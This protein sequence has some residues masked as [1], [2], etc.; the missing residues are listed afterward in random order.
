MNAAIRQFL[1]APFVIGSKDMVDHEGKRVPATASTIYLSPTAAGAAESDDIPA[2]S[3]AVAI[4]AR[5]T[6]DLESFRSA[7]TKVAAAKALKLRPLRADPTDP[8][9]IMGIVFA[10]RATAPMEDFAAALEALNATTPSERWPDAIVFAATGVINY[11]VQFPGEKVSGNWLIAKSEY[12]SGTTPPFYIPIVVCPTGPYAFDKMLLL[13]CGRVRTSSSSVIPEWDAIQAEIPPNVI[14]WSGY[15]YNLKGELKAV[16]RDQYED[17]SIPPP[18]LHI[19]DKKGTVLAAVQFLPWQDGAVIM[20]TG[21]FPLDMLFAYMDGSVLKRASVFR[22]DG[23]QMSSVVPITHAEFMA[24]LGRFQSRSN[25]VVRPDATRV[26]IQKVRDEGTSSPFVARIFLGLLY[27]RN[28]ALED[29]AARD[30][31]DRLHDVMTSHLFN[32][33]DAA[34]EIEATWEG[35]CAKVA[36]G[37]CV[38]IDGRLIHITEHIDRALRKEVDSYLNA[39]VRA[40]KEDAQ[41]LTKYLNLDIGFLFMKQKTFEAKVAALESSD[42]ELAAYLRQIRQWSEPLVQSR[43]ALEHGS[44]TL[45][46]ITYTPNDTGVDVGEPM[47][48][49]QPMTEFVKRTFDR[50]MCFAEE[51]TAYCIQRKLPANMTLT[52]IPVSK[53]TSEAPRRFLVTSTDGGLPPWH[54]IFRSDTFENL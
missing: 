51:I 21:N 39:S 42:P 48:T 14:I 52:E 40:I 32:A 8:G 43:I 50:V 45:P 16:P 23:R 20:T 24:A 17:R 1:P 26:V 19:L 44:W 33:R 7:Y 4:D 35:H 30:E 18:A 36:C 29:K 22:R 13:I 3:V 27:L 46:K 12:A 34:R 31:F 47:I 5:E 6:M 25:M 28:L 38:R 15:Q 11:A 2:D 41:Q 53:R 49:G 9:V 37:E 54:L 10:L